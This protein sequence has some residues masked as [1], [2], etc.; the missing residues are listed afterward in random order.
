[1]RARKMLHGGA[2]QG[3][4][5]VRDTWSS[6]VTT[7]SLQ[8]PIWIQRHTCRFCSFD[9]VWQSWRRFIG[10]NIVKNSHSK[11]WRCVGSWLHF[12]KY[13]DEKSITPLTSTTLESLTLYHSDHKT[14]TCVQRSD[15]VYIRADDI[16]SHVQPSLNIDFSSVIFDERLIPIA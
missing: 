3:I 8:E 15:E 9:T 16:C 2:R 4:D 5:W 11:M 13:H 14:S 6:V 10:H 12:F 1:M 7:G